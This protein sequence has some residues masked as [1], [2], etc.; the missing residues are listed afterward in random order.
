MNIAVLVKQVPNTSEIK[1]DKETG[2]LIRKGIPTIINPDDL[3]AVEVALKLKAT[4]GGKVHVFTM[5]PKSAESMLRE[6]YARGV[7]DATLLCDKA[8]AGSD[9]W[10]TSLV[11]STALK[12]HRFDLVIA[13]RQAID[14]DTAQV[15]PQVAEFLGIPHISYVDE[16]RG[17]DAT[18]CFLRKK[19]EKQSMHLKCPFPLLIT[20][21]D[22]IAKP[23]YM[24]MTHIFNNAS[25]DVEILDNDALA[26]EKADLGIKG[27]PTK[28]K[29]TY[30]KSITKKTTAESLAPEDA[31]ERILAVLREK[32]GMPDAL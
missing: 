7:D 18:H 5:G 13:G 17:V 10:S 9:T 25:R 20:V 32:G 21:L 28:V 2:A 27:S 16:I 11:L 29:K 12:R 30:A 6:L 1:V 23:R 22:G 31:A 3:S 14:G 4:H 15:G 24:N 19:E 8:F 26:I